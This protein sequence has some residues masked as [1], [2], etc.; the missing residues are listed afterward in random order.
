MKQN[1]KGQQELLQPL[2]DRL[3]TIRHRI[4]E[5][6]DHLRTNETR[7]RRSLI[8]PILEILAWDTQDPH[9]VVHEYPIGTTRVDYALLSPQGTPVIA[10]EAK[11]LGERLE[12]HIQQMLNYANPAGIPYC[13]ITDGNIWT[14]FEVFRQK[15][16]EDRKLLNIE[17]TVTPVP[18]AAIRLLHLWKPNLQSMAPEPPPQTH[19]S[20]TAAEAPTR[21]WNPADDTSSVHADSPPIAISR[22][23]ITQ[24][25]HPTV[26]HFPNGEHRPL[27]TARDIL[28]ETAAWDQRKGYLNHNTLPVRRGPRANL[29]ERQGLL[30][31]QARERDYQTLPDTDMAIYVNLTRENCIKA[32]LKIVRHLGLNP[33]AITITARAT[34]DLPDRHQ[35]TPAQ[36]TPLTQLNP[37][38]HPPP[39]EIHFPDGTQ[40]EVKAFNSIILH[41]AK[42]LCRQGHVTSSQLPIRNGPKRNLMEHVPT[43]PDQDHEAFTRVP[44]T[45]MRVLTQFSGTACVKTTVKLARLAQQDPVKILLR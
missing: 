32:A 24:H 43:G 4:G 2:T 27:K 14:V 30:P 17:I 18:N 44:G 40:A 11:R 16:I 12:P 9:Q 33:Q 28:L 1:Q 22:Y 21:S 26:L 3:A 37:T 15:P 34:P 35:P 8:D 39:A 36:W 19:D 45:D 20:Q 38:R 6:H 23:D 25:P 41:T 42:W 5:H 13:G 29:I 31:I 10:L 7:T